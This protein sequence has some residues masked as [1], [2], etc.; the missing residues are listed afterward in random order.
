MIAWYAAA[1]AS[2]ERGLQGGSVG[3]SAQRGAL[4]IHI[5]IYIYIYIYTH[6]DMFIYVLY[7]YIHIF[8]YICI[9]MCRPA[10]MRDLSREIKWLAER[11]WKPRRDL[12][13][14]KTYRGPHVFGACVN[15]R[16][17]QFHRVRD[18]KQRYFHSILCQ[19]SRDG[20]L[21][22]KTKG[23]NKDETNGHTIHIHITHNN[24]TAH[25]MNHDNQTY[26]PLRGAVP[27]AFL[28]PKALQI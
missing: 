5:H 16:R 7:T 18:F 2:R 11:D 25:N 6:R 13:L 17:L 23:N 15:N 27:A 3:R 22:G 20:P 10:S 12:R 21:R 26:W 9:Y 28:S 24:N 8:V 19:S 4:S 14:E 1:R